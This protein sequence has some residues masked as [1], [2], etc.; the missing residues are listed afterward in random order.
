M[1]ETETVGELIDHARS[2]DSVVLRCTRPHGG[3]ID[4][5]FA[6]FESFDGGT[7]VVYPEDQNRAFTK[8]IDAVRNRVTACVPDV[9]VIHIDHSRF[10][11]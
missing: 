6:S 1:S 10:R 4:I 2:I 3:E 11:E 9:E 7:W 5:T 8:G